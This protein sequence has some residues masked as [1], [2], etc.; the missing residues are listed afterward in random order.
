MQIGLVADDGTV[1]M[2]H[3][4][5][6]DP[7]GHTNEQ[8]SF[9][10]IVLSLLTRPDDEVTCRVTSSN[11]KEGKMTQDVISISSKDWD[12]RCQTI[13]FCSRS[14]LHM[15]AEQTS[16]RVTALFLLRKGQRE[17]QRV[18]RQHQYMA[19]K[20]LLRC[21]SVGF[22]YLSLCEATM[23]PCNGIHDRSCPFS[24]A[25]LRMATLLTF[26]VLVT[27]LQLTIVSMVWAGLTIKQ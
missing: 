11:E 9:G 3:G 5:N 13:P 17:G 21:I 24:M 4:S 25:L 23:Q 15:T 10:Q 19:V 2:V 27:V 12:E 7:L 6:A 18:S 14:L 22:W 16:S 20:T 26:C 1:I 8:G